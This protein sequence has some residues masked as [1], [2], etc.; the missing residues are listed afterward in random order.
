MT[1]IVLKKLGKEEIHEIKEY[2]IKRTAEKLKPLLIEA[3]ESSR[4]YRF[5][6]FE[7]DGGCR[8]HG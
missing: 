5:F 2:I 8:L 3:I 6:N 7:F 4:F 1:L